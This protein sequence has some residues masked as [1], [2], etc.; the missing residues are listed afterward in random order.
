MY[1][2]TIQVD[3]DDDICPSCGFPKQDDTNADMSGLP[4]CFYCNFRGTIGTVRMLILTELKKTGLKM[5]AKEVMTM[6]NTSEINDGRKVFTQIPVLEHLNSLAGPNK[7]SDGPM[8]KYSMLSKSKRKLTGKRGGRPLSCFKYYKVRADRFL[9]RYLANWD[10]G[11]PVGLPY[12]R[13][14]GKWEKLHSLEIR[15]KSRAIRLKL[16]SGE[17]DRFDFIFPD[18]MKNNPKFHVRK[19]DECVHLEDCCHLPHSSLCQSTEESCVTDDHCE[20][21]VE[22]K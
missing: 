13:K 5:S 19:V 4:V 21:V 22:P 15:N 18:G 2:M 17:Y 10:A 12:K 20:Y 9:D 8:R 11:R 6:L 3:I 14:K 1:I 16:R 7:N